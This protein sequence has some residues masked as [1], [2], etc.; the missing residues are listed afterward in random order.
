[1]KDSIYEETYL[2]VKE[3]AERLRLGTGTLNAWRFRGEG[4]P[5]VKFGRRVLYP[6]SQVINWEKAAMR[7]NTAL[8]ATSV[9]PEAK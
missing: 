5:F 3:L 2:T 9:L 8:P 4:P 6:F 1:M 7:K